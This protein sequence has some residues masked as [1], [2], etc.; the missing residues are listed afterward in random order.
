MT[1]TPS[2]LLETDTAPNTRSKLPEANSTPITKSKLLEVNAASNTRSELLE[3][4]FVPPVVK[5]PQKDYSSQTS[6][7][8]AILPLKKL[9][10][11]PVIFGTMKTDYSMLYN[12][13]GLS[14]EEIWTSGDDC[15]MKL[16]SISQG[17]LLKKVRTESKNTPTDIAVTRNG[18]LV[19][20]DKESRTVNVV[21]RGKIQEV[22]KLKNWKPLN[23]S[24]AS[25][26][27]LLVTMHSNDHKQA[28]VVRYSRFEEKQTV[29]YDDLGKA[30][31]SCNS[32]SKYVTEN[33]N[34]DI[35]VADQ[36]AKTV[37]VVNHAGKPRFRY[38]GHAPSPRN[39]PLRLYGIATDS[40]GNILTADDYNQC[41]HVIDRNGK[42]LGYIECG[43]R[44]PWGLYVDT[45]DNLLAAEDTEVARIRYLDKKN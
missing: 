7:K 27:D 21:T 6:L 44:Y 39:K 37:V 22:I 41:V 43:L 2:K 16:Y 5:E 29:Q 15:F 33:E 9:V 13:T 25:S 3:T 23:I 26:G 36:G 11:E 31:Y 18:D 30:L 42:F 17:H 34:L 12:V 1:N 10:V 38:T 19:Y 45:N 8:T 4:Q 40:Q 24:G 32:T 35:C 28:K 20:T 14:C